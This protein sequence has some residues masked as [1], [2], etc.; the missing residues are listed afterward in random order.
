MCG[1]S[2]GP[3]RCSIIEESK[4]E[5]FPFFMTGGYMICID[6]KIKILFISETF[7]NWFVMEMK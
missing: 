6:N 3:K 7:D 1:I 4:K 2:M 5:A